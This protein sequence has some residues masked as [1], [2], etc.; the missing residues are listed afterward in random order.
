MRGEKSNFAIYASLPKDKSLS[1]S[2]N[3]LDLIKR[4]KEEE[5]GKK[6]RKVYTL[7]GFAGLIFAL[8]IFIYL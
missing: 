1:G 3:I 5:K 8:G 4:L 2:T 6:V 7:F